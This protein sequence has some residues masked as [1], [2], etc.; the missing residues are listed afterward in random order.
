MTIVRVNHFK[1]SGG[2]AVII[3]TH[4]LYSPK[5]LHHQI[6]VVTLANLNKR[7]SEFFHHL[8][9][10]NFQR[11]PNNISYRTSSIFLWWFRFLEYEVGLYLL[12]GPVFF[13]ISSA[14]MCVCVCVTSIQRF[15]EKEIKVKE[16]EI[17][18]LLL[19]MMMIRL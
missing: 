6:M 7:F 8:K 11:N 17:A 19:M 16:K 15:T 12:V 2:V 18:V 5:K 4:I 13:S 10:F 14:V 3:F 1:G 9:V